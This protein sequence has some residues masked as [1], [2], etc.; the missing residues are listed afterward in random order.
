MG[1]GLGVAAPERALLRCVVTL[2]QALDIREILES[3]TGALVLDEESSRENVRRHATEACCDLLGPRFVE[4]D[5]INL[6]DHIDTDR[7]DP[8]LEDRARS[9][10]VGP[11]QL[12]EG[13]AERLERREHTVGI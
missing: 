5:A 9:S 1:L 3:T 6:G 12:G 2:L 11:R 13:R 8:D 7:L 10:E 4:A